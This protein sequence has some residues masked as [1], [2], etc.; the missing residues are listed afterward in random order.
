MNFVKTFAAFQLGSL[1]VLIFSTVASGE[2]FYIGAWVL[3]GWL[4]WVL[5]TVFMLLSGV[6][7][8]GILPRNVVSAQREKRL[9]ERDGGRTP[10]RE[11]EVHAGV[12][13]R[14]DAR[15]LH[16]AQVLRHL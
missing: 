13:L 3:V 15:G 14:D 12:A 10:V 1:L 5:A 11:P 7:D 6:T 8:P 16:E 4:L 9:L 2:Q